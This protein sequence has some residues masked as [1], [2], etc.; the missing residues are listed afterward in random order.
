MIK[1]IFFL[2]LFFL[3][4][5]CVFSQTQSTDSVGIKEPSLAVNHGS[6]NDGRIPLQTGLPSVSAVKPDVE[7]DGQPEPSIKK[8]FEGK[9]PI[10]SVK[11]SV[12]K[13]KITVGEKIEYRIDVTAD[14]NVKIEFPDFGEFLG[15]FIIT[16]YRQ[17]GP[18]KVGDKIKWWREYTLDVY[19]AQQYAIPPVRIMY[20]LSNGEQKQI[21]SNFVFVTVETTLS[22]DEAT[23]RDIKSLVVPEHKW[24]RK[25]V[26]II[27][28]SVIVLILIIV[29]VVVYFI[30]RKQYVE[31]PLPAHIIAL[32][33]LEHLKQQKLVEKGFFKE[34]YFGVSDILRRYIEARFGL[35]APERTSEEFLQELQQTDLIDPSQ[36]EIIK[37][38]L[39]H[40][41]MVK[42]AK[43]QPESD[44]VEKIYSITLNFIE[45]TKEIDIVDDEDEEDEED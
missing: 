4:T 17:G 18:D 40:C 3:S 22:E 15:G 16:D 8:I 29:A 41:D 23:I 7:N 30:K 36:K 9:T 10:I 25:S 45:Q 34:Y 2:I 12:N 26:S 38:F 33:A 20:R 37:D 13:A 5:S 24:S 21:L 42:F 6:E 1:K 44:E 14:E 31:P 32:K 27:I 35:M 11:T 19:L 43:Y 39:F 28:L